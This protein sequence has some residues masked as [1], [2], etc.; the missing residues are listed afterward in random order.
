MNP[1]LGLC[2]LV[3]L[4]I[5]IFIAAWR[6]YAIYRRRRRWQMLMTSHQSLHVARKRIITAPPP[7][8]D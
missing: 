8:E 3:L 6:F 1:R 4:G 7:D 2:L 5:V